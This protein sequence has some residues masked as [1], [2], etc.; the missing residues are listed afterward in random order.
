MPERKSTESDNSCLRRCVLLLVPRFGGCTLTTGTGT[1]PGERGDREEGCS[2]R[3]G[4]RNAG[5][6]AQSSHRIC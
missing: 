3:G 1:D 2:Y 5:S 6:D 4:E